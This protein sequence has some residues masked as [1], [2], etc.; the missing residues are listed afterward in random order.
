V[1]DL[2][3]LD[4]NWSAVFPA[5]PPTLGS[6]EGVAARTVLERLFNEFRAVATEV[7]ETV[8][9]S[10][11]TYAQVV[12]CADATTTCRDS[13]IADFGKRAFRRP[14]SDSERARWVGLFDGAGELIASGDAFRDGVQMVI[15]SALQSPKFLYRTEQGTGVAGENGIPL[16]GYEIA[17]RLS[18]LFVGTMPDSELFQAA[19][20]G[21]LDNAEGV[22]AQAR[23]LV[24]RPEAAERVR[25]VHARWIQLGDLDTVSKST[26]AFP[27]FTQELLESMREETLS[28]V[29]AVT[30]EE[31]GAIVQ[32]LTAPYTVVDSQL[33]NLYQLPGSFDATFQRVNL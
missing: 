9:T 7:A 20:S 12:G 17:S 4:G 31:N 29:E 15:E 22:A 21:A 33:A 32:L 18:Y 26:E 11:D 23:R 30:L 24:E 3:H 25:D 19:E 1:A 6:Y 27:Q 10:P 16:T 2:L 13:F 14:L 8:V 5:E 28:F